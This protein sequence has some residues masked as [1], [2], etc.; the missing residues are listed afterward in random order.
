MAVQPVQC[1]YWIENTLWKTQ[2]TLTSQNLHNEH[3]QCGMRK[4]T[5]FKDSDSSGFFVTVD[6]RAFIKSIL[7]CS[8]TGIEYRFSFFINCLHS[9]IYKTLKTSRI[10]I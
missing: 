6:F 8:L 7:V 1:V 10:L 4:D 3:A 5:N 9:Q 2:L